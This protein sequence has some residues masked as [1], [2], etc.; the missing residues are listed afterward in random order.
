MSDFFDVGQEFLAVRE[1]PRP[2]SASVVASIEEEVGRMSDDDSEDD[3]AE[4]LARDF[5]IEHHI[6]DRHEQYKILQLLETRI[7]DYRYPKVQPI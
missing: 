2:P 7:E 3:E 1:S 5:C 6:A 4:D